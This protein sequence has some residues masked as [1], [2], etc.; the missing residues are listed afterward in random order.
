MIRRLFR[1]LARKDEEPKKTLIIVPGQGA[2]NYW[3]DKHGHVCREP[4]D[5]QEATYG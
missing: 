4:A 2:W 3:T 5:V 1:F